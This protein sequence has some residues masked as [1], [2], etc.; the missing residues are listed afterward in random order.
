MRVD[1]RESVA[2]FDESLELEGSIETE[3]R[4]GVITGGVLLGVAV[5]LVALNLRPAIT[6][7]GPM[8]GEMRDDLGAT[9]TWAGV[10]TTLPGLCFAAAGLAAPLLARRF[11]IGA[12]IASA[13]SVLAVGLV[14]RVIDGPY[15]VLGGTLVA[16]AGI[17]LANV[18]IPVVIKDSFPARV[19]MMTGVYTAALQGGGALGSALTPP[20]ENAFGGWRQGLGAW[21]VLAVLAL[22]VWILAARGAGRAPVAEAGKQGSGRSLLRSPL[23]WMVTLFFG[24]QAFLAYVVMGWL[25]EVMIDAGVS[26][27]DSGLL[28]GLISLIAVPISLVVAPMAARHKSQS[29]WIVGLGVPG[30]VG[31]VGMMVAPAASPLLWCLLIGLGMSVF[32]LALT[33]IALRAR[34]GEDTAR[35]SGMAQGIGYL[36]A[37]VG[38]FLFGLLHDLTHGWTVPWIMM[39][40][41][42]AAQMTFGA[43]AGRRRFV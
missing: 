37:A 24:T 27:G 11:G 1:S 32:S 14:L 15:V 36:M 3:W 38:P 39:L 26:K 6:S 22:L 25:P 23:A 33:V 4:P 28:L 5:I 21:S 30:F 29:P 20:L 9:A 41:V 13:L 2:P 16:T 8:L 17:A 35:L 31:M 7:I 12:A 18:L 40:A 19:G 43:F 42:F 34:T 10:L